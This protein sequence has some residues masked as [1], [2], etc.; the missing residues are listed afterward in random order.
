MPARDS[1]LYYY[2]LAIQCYLLIHSQMNN[3]TTGLLQAHHRDRVHQAEHLSMP[4]L[5]LL[6]EMAYRH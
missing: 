5:P 4:G 3:R 1:P 2:L 6:M